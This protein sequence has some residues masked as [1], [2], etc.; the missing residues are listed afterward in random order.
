MNLDK[1]EKIF[2]EW[3]KRYSENPEEFSSILD[4]EGKPAKDYGHACALYFEQLDYE[5]N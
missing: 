3:A 4:S 5:L 1:L 2:N